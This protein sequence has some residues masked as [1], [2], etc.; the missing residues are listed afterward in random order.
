MATER[1]ANSAETTLTASITDS[2]NTLT[3]LSRATFPA[4]PQ[5]RIRIDDELMLVTAVADTTWT[6]DR[7]I[8]DT[9]RAPHSNGATV[10]QVLTAGAM[11]NLL[12]DQ[13][14]NTGEFL[15][16][17]G[18]TPSWAAVAQVPTG[19]ILDFAAATAPTGYLACDGSAVSRT[20][21]AALFAVVSTTWGAGD[22]STTFNVPD[23]RGRTAIGSG[24]GSG[25]SARTLA[26]T[27]GA[28][29]HQLTTTEIPSHAHTTGAIGFLAAGTGSVIW[30]GGGTRNVAQPNTGSTG[31]DG[32]HNNMQPFRVTTK[33]IKT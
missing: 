4:A 32:A 3:V 15:T 13:T 9:H 19:T 23:L 26:A 6:V 16:T 21:Y 1:F 31:G 22:G 17:N 29:T 8:E 24:T 28:E 11:G 33:I 20:T 30:S 25:L 5:F 7:E 12:P 27:G 2:T 14:G 18:T 10:T